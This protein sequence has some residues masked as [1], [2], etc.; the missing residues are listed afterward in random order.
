MEKTGKVKFINEEIKKLEKIR[1]DLQELCLHK[2]TTVKF[3]ESN[4]LRVVCC[5]CDKKL[6]YPSQKELETFFHTNK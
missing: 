4:N 3:D 5:D 2:D 1:E 6:K